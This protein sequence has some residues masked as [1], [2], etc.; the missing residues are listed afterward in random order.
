MTPSGVSFRMTEGQAP[1]DEYAN[2]MGN[3]PTRAGVRV[4]RPGQAEV[5]AEALRLLEAAGVRVL[6]AGAF[7]HHAYTGVW[8]DTK[9]LDF[10]VRREDV[11]AALDALS[12]AGFET[13]LR[14]PVWLAKAWRGEYLLDFIFANSNGKLL[15]D[16]TWFERSRP[17][18]LGGLRA[19]VISLEDLIASKVYIAKR[20]RFDG[21]DILHL[22]RCAW[23]TVDWP[24]VLDRLGEDR[25]L[26]FWYLVLF[27]AVYP[28][29][30]DLLPQ[31]LMQEL[32]QEMRERWNGG[33]VD[34]KRFRGALIDEE[35][36]AIDIDDWGY[37]DPCPVRL[38]VTWEP[39]R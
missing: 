9:D 13:E 15:V 16:E 14:H 10:F 21:A 29:H 18:E 2:P 24:R 4:F 34:W 7:A 12:A 33:A 25:S 22:I 37:E 39:E 1:G 3:L 20:D 30:S 26:L 28:G 36:F 17:I 35:A 6:L 19:R 23:G 8:R 5:L 11:G 31:E 27:D 32:F 38:P